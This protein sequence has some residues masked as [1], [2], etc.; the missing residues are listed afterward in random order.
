MASL[1][2]CRLRR[3]VPTLI[4]MFGY[5]TACWMGSPSVSSWCSFNVTVEEG[6]RVRRGDSVGAFVDTSCSK[7]SL[8][9]IVS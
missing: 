9:V 4:D 6:L 2:K 3:V 8:R 5:G 7:D 1:N